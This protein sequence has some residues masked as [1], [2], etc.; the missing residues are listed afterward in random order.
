MRGEARRARAKAPSGTPSR[1]RRSRR[2]WRAP[3]RDWCRR[4]RTSDR[5]RPPASIRRWRREDRPS[6]PAPRR[7][8]CAPRRSRGPTLTARWNAVER[9]GIV[10]A[11]P[12]G[13]AERDVELRIARIALDR[14]LRAAQPSSEDFAAFWACAGPAWAAQA[15]RTSSRNAGA[16][17]ARRP[18]VEAAG[19]SWPR[20]P[21]G[22]TWQ[23]E[24]TCPPP[25]SCPCARGAARAGSWPSPSRGFRRTA[26]RS[27]TSASVVPLRA[28]QESAECLA[29]RRVIGMLLRPAS[30]S[31]SIAS[32]SF[33]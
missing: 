3:I 16:V 25:P 14:R 32:A 10:V 28:H 6:P 1:P 11:L 19:A 18:A 29:R 30:R 15:N 31:I 5:A 4:G 22:A 13:Q 24:L 2:S 23:L 7:A 20:L 8:S 21:S 17:M 12:V 9:A 33:P 27:W 26:F